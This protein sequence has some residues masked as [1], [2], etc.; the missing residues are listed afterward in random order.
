MQGRRRFMNRVK[1]Q[2]DGNVRP[3]ACWLNQ[4]TLEFIK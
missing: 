3:P 4:L 2:E 1:H